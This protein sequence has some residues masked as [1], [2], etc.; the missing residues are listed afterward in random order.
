MVTAIGSVP[1]LQIL[2]SHHC[3]MNVPD[4]VVTEMYA[5]REKKGG[6]LNIA[7]FSIHEYKHGLMRI[8]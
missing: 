6:V 2:P 1:W 4:S 5:N 7:A 3:C 8:M